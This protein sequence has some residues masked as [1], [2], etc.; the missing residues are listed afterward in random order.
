MLISFDGAEIPTTLKGNSLSFAV[1][2]FRPVLELG[3]HP[4]WCNFY[5]SPVGGAVLPTVPPTHAATD[6]AVVASAPWHLAL[7][8]LAALVAGL[9]VLGSRSAEPRRH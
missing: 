9:L 1:S 7:V 4:Y 6:L 3:G 2:G 8:G 5:N